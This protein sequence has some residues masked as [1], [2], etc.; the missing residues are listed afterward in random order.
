MVAQGQHG[1]D[2]LALEADL[3]LVG[4]QDTVAGEHR[5][6]GRGHPGGEQPP[7]L[8]WQDDVGDRGVHGQAEQLAGLVVDER[9]PAGAV[10][11]D[12][13][14]AH[15]V[16]DGVVVLVHPGHLGRPEPVGLP[17][18]TPAEQPRPGRG[19]QQGQGGRHDH[20]GGAAQQPGVDGVGGDADRD[21]R[22]HGAG[23]V[24]YGN[25]GPHRLA[26]RAPMPFDDLAT[27]EGGVD[28]PDER[29]PDQ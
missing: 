13:A 12:Q 20:G 8:G 21:Q 4:D 26:Q 18:Q 7:D 3:A 1:A 5:L 17:A 6:V 22:D 27:G 23:P 25:D 28:R 2:G 16:Q 11:H 24:A 10:D 29:L 19:E 15:R 9:D 14:L